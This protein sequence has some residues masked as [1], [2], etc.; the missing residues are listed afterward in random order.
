MANSVGL[1]CREGSASTL[2]CHMTSLLLQGLHMDK[3]V[4][5]S[6]TQAKLL[7]TA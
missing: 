6:L 1:A 7:W 4:V 3:D 2:E 5:C